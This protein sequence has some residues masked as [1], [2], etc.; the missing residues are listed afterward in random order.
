MKQVTGYVTWDVTVIC[1]HCYKKLALNQYPYDS[2][3][4]E[5]GLALF[6]RANEPAKWDG[7]DIKYKC[8]GCKKSFSLDFLDI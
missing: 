3:K 8:C 1:P 6:G 2:A 7:L 4:D 5:L